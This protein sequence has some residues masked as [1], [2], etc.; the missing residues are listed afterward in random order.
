[1]PPTPIEKLQKFFKLEAERGYDNRAVVGGLDKVLPAWL[2]EA[3]AAKLDE[4]LLASVSTRLAQYGDLEPEGSRSIAAVPAGC[5]C[6]NTRL[7]FNLPKIQSK[8]GSKCQRTIHALSACD[9]KIPPL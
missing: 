9:L 1:M 3:E 7:V 5:C 4:S 6:P 8:T 2:K